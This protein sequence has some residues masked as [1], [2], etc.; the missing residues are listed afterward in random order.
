VLLILEV[1]PLLPDDSVSACVDS[2]FSPSSRLDRLPNGGFPWPS[3][4]R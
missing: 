2:L 1:I 3:P 4:T